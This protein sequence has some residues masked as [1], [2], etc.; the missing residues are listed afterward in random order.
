MTQLAVVTS[1]AASLEGNE[2]LA[3]TVTGPSI[4][5]YANFSTPDPDLAATNIGQLFAVFQPA[6]LEEDSPPIVVP[7]VFPNPLAPAGLGR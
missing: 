7:A 6:M 3:I 4:G 5:F 2:V 1:G